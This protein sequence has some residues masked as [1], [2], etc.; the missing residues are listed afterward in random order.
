MSDWRSTQLGEVITFKNGFAFKSQDFTE[1]GVPIIKIKN[2]KPNKINLDTLSFV[3][4]G[5]AKGKENYLIQPEDIL[6]TMSGNRAD[7]SPDSWV[8]KAAQFKLRG[9]YL[10]NQRVSAI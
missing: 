6:I 10:L 5:T 7:G 2:V 8:G 1:A 3:T 9:R 4:E